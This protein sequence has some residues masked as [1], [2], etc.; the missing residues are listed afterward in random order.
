[1]IND[2]EALQ[3]A[4][5]SHNQSNAI[6][7]LIGQQ[8]RFYAVNSTAQMQQIVAPAPA[9]CYNLETNEYN[10]RVRGNSLGTLNENGNL[11]GGDPAA[12]TPI[13]FAQILYPV[14]N[15][16]ELDGLLATLTPPAFA[17]RRDTHRYYALV[18]PEGYGGNTGFTQMRDGQGLLVFD[19]GPQVLGTVYVS[20][21]NEYNTIYLDWSDDFFANTGVGR[22]FTIDVVVNEFTQEPRI[23][24]VN[25]VTEIT[26]PSHKIKW[27]FTPEYD[28]STLVGKIVRTVRTPVRSNTIVVRDTVAPVL[29][30]MVNVI[31]LTGQVAL[32]NTFHVAGSGV[33]YTIMEIFSGINGQAWRY[34]PPSSG[35]FRHGS[36]ITM[37]G[38]GNPV[39]YPRDPNA[40]I[41]FVHLYESNTEGYL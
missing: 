33:Q 24:Q 8:F 19:N 21:T 34:D 35:A 28:T 25:S 39:M 41:S 6:R 11:D 14:A 17:F 4:K 32:N 7:R 18:G 29:T 13:T 2:S 10:L 9:V 1:M 22:Q 16:A 23:F 30:N 20:G 38:Q 27:S 40:W 36:T 37:D 3:L 15:K 12:W 26:T 5:S 31:G